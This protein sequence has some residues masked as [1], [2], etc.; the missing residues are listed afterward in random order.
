VQF[1][2][3]GVIL[4]I[5]PQIT[6][7]GRVMLHIEPE[8]STGQINPTTQ[9]PDK[10]TTE[11]TTDVMLHDGQGMIIGGLIKEN[12]ATVQNKIPWLGNVHKLGWF[13][14]RS[15]VTKERAE[16]IIA[17]LPRIQPYEPTYQAFEQG[18][19]VK[20]GVPLFHGPL[21]RSNRPWDPILPDGHRVSVPL[22]PRKAIQRKQN[23]P[24]WPA[25]SN[26][27]VVP[28]QPT[29]E[30][31]FSDATSYP[32]QFSQ[33]TMAGPFL[34]DE[35]VPMPGTPYQSQPVEIISDQPRR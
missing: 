17:V 33:P 14:R 32:E 31:R 28:E 11:L 12:D 26:G 4:S 1:L 30:Q 2:E 20:A 15:E 7:D 3:V 18:E 27:Y 10:S 23:V 21:N 8:V 22:N 5:T 25:H 9:V 34:S 24:P 19:L 29:P 13:F 16:I 6:R 35:A